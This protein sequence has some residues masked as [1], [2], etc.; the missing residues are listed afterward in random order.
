MCASARLLYLQPSAKR[1]QVHLCRSRP[2]GGYAERVEEERVLQTC[3]LSCWGM[4]ASVI[5]LECLSFSP[6]AGLL[7]G[8]LECSDQMCLRAAFLAAH[9]GS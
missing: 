5:S 9:G 8:Q 1:P 2:A 3:V 7:L 6:F 4:L